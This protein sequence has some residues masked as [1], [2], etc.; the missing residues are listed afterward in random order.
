MPPVTPRRT[1][2]P[3]SKLLDAN[4]VGTFGTDVALGDLLEGDRERLFAKA[5]GLDERRHELSAA[6]AELVVIG[7]DLARALRGDDHE[8]VLRVDLREQI[9]DLRFDHAEL[10]VI[11][12]P[13]GG[14]EPSIPATSSTTRP[15]SSFTITWSKRSA[16][17]ISRS[18]AETRRPKS[19]SPWVP[20]S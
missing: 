9:V 2:R 10:P 18:A 13:F 20:R 6:F 7:V 15:T 16:S 5:A 17:S 14:V 19:S 11:E 3:A 8:R 1:R 12:G 4:S